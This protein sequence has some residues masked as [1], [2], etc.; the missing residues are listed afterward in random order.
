MFGPAR[1]MIAA[2]I[3]LVATALDGVDGWLARRMKATTAFGARFDMEV[4]AALVMVLSI[5]VWRYGKAGAWVLASGL[6]R[7][8]F[9]ASGA[10]WPWMHAPLT[11]TR[12][13]KFICVIQLGALIIAMLPM[14]PVPA[15]SIVAGVGLAALIYSFGVDVRRLRA[16]VPS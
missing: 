5:L 1:P 14:V 4:D 8:A 3:A 15:S 11:P 6:L 16:G 13:A 12:R 7:Y 2:S 10:I 9:V